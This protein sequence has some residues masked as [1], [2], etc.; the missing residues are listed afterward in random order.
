MKIAVSG[1]TGQL[2]SLVLD[3]ALEMSHADRVGIARNPEKAVRLAARG[4]EIRR[5]DYPEP[6]RSPQRLPV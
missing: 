6:R 3:R 4:V 1:A 5:G 2:G